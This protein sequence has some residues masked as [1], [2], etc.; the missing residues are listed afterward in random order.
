M[1]GFEMVSLEVASEGSVAAY[2][3]AVLGRAGRVDVLVN[4]VGTGVFG[5]AEEISVDEVKGLFEINFFGA[6]RVT[7]AVLPIMREQRSGRIINMSSPG[8]V[9]GIPFNAVYCASKFALE[10]YAE[11]LRHEVRPFGIYVSI[12]EPT[13]VRTSAAE[14]VPRATHSIE[15]YAAVRER[16]NENFIRSMRSGMDPR[17]VAET[18]LQI[19]END[20]PRLRYTVGRQAAMVSLMRRTL[21]QGLFERVVRRVFGLDH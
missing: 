10:G 12:V 9:A 15:A 17:L 6:V 7:N 8:G 16:V 1:N 14:R 11:S 19:I 5:A 18:V 21:P 3:Q 20:T 13:G 2:V 4:N